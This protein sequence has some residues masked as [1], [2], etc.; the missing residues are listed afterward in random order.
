MRWSVRDY[1]QDG[2]SFGGRPY[3]VYSLSHVLPD[4]ETDLESICNIAIQVLEQ[5][6]YCQQD[7]DQDE[8]EAPP[9]DQAEY[10]GV[11]ISSAGDLVGALAG[12]LGPDFTPAFN[13]FYPLI[14]KYCVSARCSIIP[15]LDVRRRKRVARP[16]TEPRLS[17]AWLRL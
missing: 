1:Q 2:A 3:G 4:V 11:L 15:F 17:D 8:E 9:E 5:K 14:V 16:L 12:A 6:A 7:P 13:T 10:D